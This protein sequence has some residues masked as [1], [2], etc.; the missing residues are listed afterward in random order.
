MADET[1]IE[2]QVRLVLEQQCRDVGGVIARECPAGVG[3]AL[4]M[5]DFGDCGSMAYVSNG[6]RDYMVRALRELLQRLEAE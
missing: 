3:F 2:K 5:F 4:V 6:Q 1:M